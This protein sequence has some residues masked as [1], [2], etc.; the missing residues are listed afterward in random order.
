MEKK[1]LS[2]EELK[3][4]YLDQI[5][6]ACES[7]KRE[8]GQQTAKV[9]RLKT[10]LA[11]CET[12]AGRL[13]SELDSL[14][15]QAALDIAEGKPI[16][17]IQKKIRQ[18]RLGLEDV[19]GLQVKLGGE[20]LPAEEQT[21]KQRYDELQELFIKQS[22]SIRQNSFDQR[23]DELVIELGNLTASYDEAI[24]Q[25]VSEIGV[26]I[27]WGTIKHLE[28]GKPSYFSEE[29]KKKISIVFAQ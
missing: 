12:N 8:V 15:S 19:K 18:I 6:Q 10:K 21:L 1:L 2:A 23:M 4:R 14:N 5:T 28:L 27:G 22:V 3:K 29:A 25:A 20:I 7:L 9:D 13:K 16:D 17:S 11:E 26:K 24:R